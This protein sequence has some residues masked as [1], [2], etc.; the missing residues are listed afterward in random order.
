MQNINS[1]IKR[2]IF[3]VLFIL[4]FIFPLLFCTSRKSNESVKKTE[5]AAPIK[6]PQYVVIT[7]QTE[8]E[9]KALID[10]SGDR[11]LIFDLY[12]DWCK[13]CKILSPV[14]EELAKE[15]RHKASFFKVN[16]DK[17]KR[18]GSMFRV[19]GIPFV[20]F[21]KNKQGVHS[22]TGVMPKERYQQ[23]INKFSADTG[24]SPDTV[25]QAEKQKDV[26]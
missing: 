2:D 5:S 6:Q 20:V 9:F 15:N 26:S 4:T 10:T 21:V 23:A 25:I 8:A 19:A 18:I 12:A 16:I 14:L 17:H 22:L 1:H 3:S 11:L 7:I 13:P 24:D